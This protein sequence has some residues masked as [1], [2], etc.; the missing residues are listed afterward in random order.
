MS[1]LTSENKRYISSCEFKITSR[2]DKNFLFNIDDIIQFLINN[3]Q[4]NVYYRNNKNKP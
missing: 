2:K 3:Y 1:I 4:N